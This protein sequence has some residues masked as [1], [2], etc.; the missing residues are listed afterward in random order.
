MSCVAVV[1][2]EVGILRPPALIEDT[3]AAQEAAALVVKLILTFLELLAIQ[4]PAEEAAPD[5]TML[6]TAVVEVRVL[7]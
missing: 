3:L 4:I 2:A 5:L 6:S 1:A 7:L